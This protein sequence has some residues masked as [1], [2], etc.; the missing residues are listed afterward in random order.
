[1]KIPEYIGLDTSCVKASYRK[2]VDAIARDDYW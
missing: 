2:V 1:M